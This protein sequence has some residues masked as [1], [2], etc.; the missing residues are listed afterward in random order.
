VTDAT[1]DGVEPGLV[2]QPIG[3]RSAVRPIEARLVSDQVVIELRRSIVSGQLKPG[4]GLSLRKL[5]DALGVSFIPVRDALKVLET[6]GL[7]VNP[8]GRSATVSP[9]DLDELRGIYRVR[10]LLEPD[11][12]RRA[13]PDISA[14]E[15]DRLYDLAG[16]LGR[17]DRSMADTYQ[18]HSAFHYG[19]L[20]P[21]TSAWDTRILH[22]LWTA[23]ERYVRI[24]F[25]LLDPDPTEHE[26]RAEAHRLLVRE[27]RT[28]DPTRA[29]QALWEH[30]S[31]NEELATKAL[32]TYS[33]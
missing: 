13:C 9:L 4:E 16:E 12:A 28:G 11:L 24:A 22:L 19:L 25:G 26:R 33:S 18:D 8:P 30:L 2:V 27:Y 14:A 10:L 3:A 29:G 5:A 6:E 31:L 21:A 17:L 23:S 1:A 7:I 15:L 20:R 32:S